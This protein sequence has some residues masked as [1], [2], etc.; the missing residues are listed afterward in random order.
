MYLLH[1]I[2]IVEITEIIMAVGIKTGA[3]HL[4]SLVEKEK[5]VS[6]K[7]ASQEL[8]VSLEVIEAWA[9]VLQ[10]QELIDIEYKFMGIYLFY[11]GP[12]KKKE[13]EKVQKI[14]Q[15]SLKGASIDLND[16]LG[17]FKSH[18]DQLETHFKAHDLSIL[19]EDLKILKRLEDERD[20]VD[21][22]LVEIQ[23]SKLGKLKDINKNFEEEEKHT[24]L[25]L[26]KVAK[27][28][29]N[30]KH[31]LAH[32]NAELKVLEKNK[33]FLDRRLKSLELVLN[34]QLKN[35]GQTT[36][37]SLIK[38]HKKLTEL[39]NAV[40]RVHGE[41]ELDKKN[42]KSAMKEG[43]EKEKIVLRHRKDIDKKLRDYAK[44]LS[45]EKKEKIKEVLTHLRKRDELAEVLSDLKHEEK[46]LQSFFQ[47]MKGNKNELQQ[48]ENQIKKISKMRGSFELRVKGILNHV[49][50]EKRTKKTTRKK[51]TKKVSRKKQSGKK[52]SKS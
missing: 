30:E 7:K 48:I 15:E 2:N 12:E 3:D 1:N 52:T 34:D 24:E 11:E 10:T 14:K 17:K 5:K 8:G 27:E 41:L 20:I 43:R 36:D 51:A 32:E 16:Y 9:T 26:E 29:I 19:S 4:L 31:I 6:V 37:K 44:S 25:L 46:Q 42:L 49:D 45:A 21:R 18:I 40:L 23:H 33:S 35:I 38:A 47:E 13:Q 50:K 22:E 39:Q 28:E